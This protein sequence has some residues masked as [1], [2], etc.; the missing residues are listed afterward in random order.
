MPRLVFSELNTATGF[1]R[2]EELAITVTVDAGGWAEEVTDSPVDVIDCP[3]DV[4]D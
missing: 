4:I 1:G 2:A 3:V